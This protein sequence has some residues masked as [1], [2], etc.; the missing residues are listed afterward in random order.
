MLRLHLI[1]KKVPMEKAKLIFKTKI[2]AIA[3]H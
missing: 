1:S 2:S 3:E